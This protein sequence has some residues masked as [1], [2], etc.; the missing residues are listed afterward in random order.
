MTKNTSHHHPLKIKINQR[1]SGLLAIVGVGLVLTIFSIFYWQKITAGEKLAKLLPA[2]RTLAFL[3]FNLDPSRTET[4]ELQKLLAQNPLVQ[5]QFNYL[6]SLAPHGDLFW[7]WFSGRGG[8][9][10]LSNAQGQALENVLFLQKTNQEKTLNWINELVLDPKNDVV[11]DEDYYG[12]KLLSFRSGQTYNLMLTSDYLVLAENRDNLKL[13][14]ETIAGKHSRLRELPAYNQLISALP[15]QNVFFLYL[16]RDKILSVLGRDSQFLAGR[17]AQFKLY[18]PFL[19]LFSTEAIAVKLER[20]DQNQ[21]ILAAKHLS[22]FNQSKFPSPNLFAT[23]Y[24]YQG[25]L[26]Y[27]LPE[28]AFFQAGGVNLLDQKNKLQAYFKNN[29]TVYDL[30]FSGVISSLRDTLQS[31]GKK[32]DLDQNFFPLFP[33]EYLLFAQM[34]EAKPELGLIFQSENPSNDL[35]KLKPLLEAFGPKLAA[36]F[37]SQVSPLTL[38]DGTTGSELKPE[39]VAPSTSS[40]TVKGKSVEKM[41]ISSGYNLYIFA[42][43]QAKVILVTD[44]LSILENVLGQTKTIPKSSYALD[45]PTEVYQLNLTLSPYAAFL[46]PLTSIDIARKFT[47]IGLLSVY[48]LGF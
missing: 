7:Q 1:L 34:G 11:L 29:S 44:T 30:L 39:L 28:G 25:N 12:Q 8:V 45:K 3:E 24:S 16:N 5:G 41:S 26:E 9:A 31:P 42:D 6:M 14:A 36:V 18:F 15:D 10:I 20:N 27:L 32:L 46:K 48:Q 38:P 37:D 35:L 17:L 40:I 13:I 19:Q 2:D 4:V 23:D 47:E 21:P 22:L 43:Q 33:Q